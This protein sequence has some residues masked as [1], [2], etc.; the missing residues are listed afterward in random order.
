MLRGQNLDYKNFDGKITKQCD[1]IFRKDKKVFQRVTISD[2]L[3]SFEDVAKAEV[4]LLPDRESVK[5]LKSRA[6]V[7]NFKINSEGDWELL[8]ESEIWA[9]N[10]F[11]NNA[12]EPVSHDPLVLDTNPFHISSTVSHNHLLIKFKS[13]D[14][15]EEI[16]KWKFLYP[17][18]LRDSAFG[19]YYF[20]EKR[21]STATVEGAWIVRTMSATAGVINSQQRYY[22]EIW[23]DYD[24]RREA[25]PLNYNEP[26]LEIADFNFLVQDD[27]H[28]TIE[29]VDEDISKWQL[30]GIS[31]AGNKP[32]IGA[33]LPDETDAHKWNMSFAQ[34]KGGDC[35][36]GIH[37]DTDCDIGGAL[38][39][40]DKD[41]NVEQV[42]D[43]LKNFRLRELKKIRKAKK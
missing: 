28:A 43:G 11:Y 19:E 21:E 8:L 5:H 22:T 35:L 13:D 20:G 14:T 3:K 7:R 2:L 9:A 15:H 18:Q 39:K 25:E 31:D 30:G 4:D 33:I 41:S 26:T 27:Y 34:L 23:R 32:V 16:F 12:E 36:L 10:T 17:L 40:I 37:K 6:V 29:N 1:L 24:S 42:G 38:Y